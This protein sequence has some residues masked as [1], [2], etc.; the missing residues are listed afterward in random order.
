MQYS[1]GIGINSQLHNGHGLWSQV[2]AAF[3]FFP[4]LGVASSHLLHMKPLKTLEL[5]WHKILYS[6]ILVYCTLVSNVFYGYM[7]LASLCM[8]TAIII[9]ENALHRRDGKI[10]AAI[11]LYRLGLILLTACLM[12][13]YFV[14]PFLSN[15]S[16]V[17]DVEHRKWKFD[18]VGI[19]WLISAFKDGDLLDFGFRYKTITILSSLGWCVGFS[20]L[21]CMS[22]LV[23]DQNVS[24]KTMR[25]GK[26][27]YCMRG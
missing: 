20:M 11:T 26:E 6:G 27:L 10:L 3:V 19:T 15:R 25:A 22:Y 2:L 9:F 24:P 16:F 14:I 21:C 8:L 12:S 7:L 5:E 23:L 1:Y 4:A 17:C 13:S 18:S